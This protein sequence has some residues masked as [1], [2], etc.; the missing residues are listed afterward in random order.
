MRKFKKILALL[1]SAILLTSC[2]D[3]K[4][5]IPPSAEEISAN[6]GLLSG[7]D[8]CEIPDGMTFED[9]CNLVYIGGKQIKMPCTLKNLEKSAENYTLI[10]DDG[11]EVQPEDSIMLAYL[12]KDN[13]TI[14]AV[15]F[16]NGDVAH[17]GTADCTELKI[18]N[19]AGIGDN[20]TVLLETMGCTDKFEITDYAAQYDLW[21]TDG[22]N[23]VKISAT[24][25]ENGIISL[26]YFHP[27]LTVGDIPDKQPEDNDSNVYIPENKFEITGWTMEEL[28]SDITVNGVTLSL[29]CSPDVFSSFETEEFDFEGTS[30]RVW[31][32]EVYSGDRIIAVAYYDS[33]KEEKSVN[34]LM[35]DSLIYDNSV[36]PEFNIMGITD[37]S[38]PAEV[39]AILGEP[40]F[41]DGYA[42]DYVYR[43]S[44]NKEL[45]ISFD[46]ET[47]S[48]IKFLRIRYIDNQ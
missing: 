26:L 19:A 15:H 1:L 47:M 2:A 17:I 22:V 25:D 40:N 5:Y 8:Y 45:Y 33:E 4:G 13:T 38:T 31:G 11:N 30:G 39:S 21:Y 3:N 18:N 36:I 32:C 14:H 10:D 12:K 37:K 9:I 23:A 24:T 44:E 48:T 29:P 43:F 20:I 28:V 35:L 41:D 46:A 6:A 27:S 34:L 7:K 16:K 42:T